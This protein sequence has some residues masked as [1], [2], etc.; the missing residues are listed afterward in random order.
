MVW[1]FDLY[2]DLSALTAWLFVISLDSDTTEAF[3]E[4]EEGWKY[5]EW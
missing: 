5:S 1:I 3:Q 4:F 2:Q